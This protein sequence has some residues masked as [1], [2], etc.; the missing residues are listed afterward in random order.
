MATPQADVGAHELAL[1]R[2]SAREFFRREV[3]PNQERWAEQ[4]HVDRELWNKAGEAGLLLAGV[5]E[6]LGGGGGTFAHEAVVIE[7]QGRA[8]DTA[9]GQ[10]LHSAIC[11]HYILEYGTPEQQQRWLPGM[12]SGEIVAAIAMTE[13][14]AGSDLK[15]VRTTAVLEGDEYV[16]DGAKTF[17]SN[18][19]HAGI[20]ITVATTDP[21]AG[22]HGISLLVV[23]TA[24]AEGFS[25][26]RVLEKLGWRG[27]D[28]V[29]LFYEK[30]RVPA[31]NLLGG[32][33]G[34]G[35]K[36]LMT[37]L[38]RER[39]V[40][41]VSAVS[42]A[43]RILEDTVTYSK[44]RQLFDANLFALQNT[45]FELA[46]C[47][48]EVQ[49]GRVFVDDCIRRQV[50]GTL[51]ASSASMAKWWCTDMQGRVIDRCLQL[52]GGYGFM[53]EYPVCQAYADARITRIAGGA[54][55][56]MKELIARSL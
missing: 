36:Q 42:I 26:G 47:A 53:L 24:G 41:A 8:L 30:V 35:F 46:E 6:E 45:R 12:A 3:T 49:L 32:V 25:R 11:A 16:I 54:N 1:F 37:Q 20:V 52:H 9:F 7:E 17:I 18:G 23:E 14:G 31:A 10:Q 5:P 43:E 55:E 4:H 34:Q 40:L 27:Q 28:T 39:L 33:E 29:E 44:E 38:P 21:S 50:E 48:T 22:A 51:D 56:V 19:I 2:E 13:P 15:A